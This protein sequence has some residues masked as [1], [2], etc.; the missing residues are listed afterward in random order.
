MWSPYRSEVLLIQHNAQNYLPLCL[1][2]SLELKD[3]SSKLTSLRTTITSSMWEPPMPLGRVSR[4]KLPSSPP[5][6]TFCLVWVSM[7]GCFCLSPCGIQR[8]HLK[9]PQQV[10]AC[11]WVEGL[12]PSSVKT[13]LLFLLFIGS[14]ASLS[15]T[16]SQRA[17]NN[18]SP[19]LTPE[20]WTYWL[21]RWAGACVGLEISHN[22]L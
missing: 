17:Y 21:W 22:A 9:Q 11:R 4:V 20:K 15:L 12:S 13:F 10:P 8:R 16:T 3:S 6:V 7:S 5:E 18:I 2:L 14:Q 1:D 19:G